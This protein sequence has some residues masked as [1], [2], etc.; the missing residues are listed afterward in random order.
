MWFLLAYGTWVP[1]CTLF[2]TKGSKNGTLRHAFC[3]ILNFWSSIGIILQDH[4]I[5]I[6]PLSKWDPNLHSFLAIAVLCCIECIIF[7]LCYY[8]TTFLFTLLF[9]VVLH[10]H[11][12]ISHSNFFEIIDLHCSLGPSTPY[13]PCSFS[14]RSFFKSYCLLFWSYDLSIFVRL[15]YEIHDI[16]LVK[17]IKDMIFSVSKSNIVWKSYSN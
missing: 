1:C 6:F 11:H 16:G 14:A 12:P 15:F 7:K 9:H 17:H 5:H 8:S 13:L 10:C 3:D 4:Q 2:F